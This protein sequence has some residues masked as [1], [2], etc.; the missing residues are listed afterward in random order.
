MLQRLF[1][2]LKQC[3]EKLV[4]RAA[5]EKTLLR[6]GLLSVGVLGCVVGMQACGVFRWMNIVQLQVLAGH[7][8]YLSA[9]DAQVSLLSKGWTFAE[10]VA[11]TLYIGAALMAQKRFLKRSYICLLAVLA[12]G[13]PGLL[14]VLWHGVLFVAQPICCIVLL[15]LVTIPGKIVSRKK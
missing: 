10:C 11:V 6:W 13:L 15:W 12:L 1:T 3:R 8:F 9:E 2:A 7:P 5:Q 4:E 14:C